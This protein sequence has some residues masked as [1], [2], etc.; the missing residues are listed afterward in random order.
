MNDYSPY[1]NWID[2][3]FGRCVD[4]LT[5]WANV[6]SGTYNLSGLEKMCSMLEKEVGALGGE[7][8]TIELEPQE[9]VDRRGEMV[10]IPLGKALLVRK[11]PAADL[12][13]FFCVHMDTV[14]DLE[15]PF[16]KCHRVHENELKGPGVADAKGGLLV[17]L[18]AV[19]AFERSPWA[20]NLGWDILINPDEEVGSPGSA[21]LLEEAAR[22]NH[23][24][25]VYEPA[26][27]GGRLVSTRKGSGNFA[28]V[29]RGRAA[30]AGRSPDLGRNAI[31]ALAEFIVELNTFADTKKGIAL[32]VGAITGGGAVNVVPDL[33]L[34]RFN[35]RV[36]SRSDQKSFEEKL[37][38]L[39][40]KINARDGISV[41]VHGNFARPPKPLEGK[42]L[43]L[44]THI[45]V[46][47]RELGM[48]VTWISTG[49][50]CDGNNLYSAG[51]PTIDS[52]GVTGGNLHS[53]DE[54]VV[55]DSLTERARLTAL[56]LMKL[57]S[58]EI[59]WQ[60]G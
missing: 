7:T 43:E 22:N 3:R 17:M 54:Y 37:S 34:C 36:T 24:G 55:L 40:A 18:T 23:L 26:Q 46:C 39:V 13:V 42:S 53:I 9:V 51:L 32:N 10:Q 49:G 4:L 21:P 30:H 60:S 29:I 31:D 52:L 16:Q 15:H 19:Q 57:A 8:R 58:G 35:V 27:A 6:N 14:Y 44:A 50:V 45:E 1:L 47:G 41:E 12:R 48:P 5:T 59:Q 38:S 11:L 56:L 28:V 33:A 25:L 20:A 2:S